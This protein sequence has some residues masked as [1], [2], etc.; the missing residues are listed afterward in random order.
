[1]T[2]KWTWARPQRNGEVEVWSR[3]FGPADCH[4]TSEPGPPYLLADTTDWGQGYIIVSWIAYEQRP[5]RPKS[6][7]KRGL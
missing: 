2:W 5:P 7:P 6:R 4:F 1:M 3:W